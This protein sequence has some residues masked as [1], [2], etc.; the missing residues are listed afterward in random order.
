MSFF[1]YDR[2]G[3]LDI[4]VASAS[5]NHIL[6]HN[7]GNDANWVGFILEGTISNRDAIGS[8]IWLYAA[9]EIQTRHLRAGTDWIEQE[10]I[11]LHFG[12][13]YE[14]NVESVVIRWPLGHKQVLTDVEI[15]QYH[16]IKEPDYTSP[17]ENTTNAE[18]P[19]NFRLEQNYPNPFI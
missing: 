19:N 18:K 8:L 4:Y 14:T 17:V 9:D 11:W 7:F 2:D 3:F 5:D 1:D 13:G 12:L 16:N 15:N 10:N 6:Y